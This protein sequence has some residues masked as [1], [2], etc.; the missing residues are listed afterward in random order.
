[1]SIFHIF[2]KWHSFSRWLPEAR[3]IINFQY[4]GHNLTKKH[5]RLIVNYRFGV[6]NVWRL[7]VAVAVAEGWPLVRSK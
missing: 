2:K 6:T 3:K 4:F 5:A 7:A 1:M